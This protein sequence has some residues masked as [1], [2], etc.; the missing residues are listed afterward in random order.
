MSY[1]E[2]PPEEMQRRAVAFREDMQRRRSVREFSTRTV[3]RD[4]IEHCVLTAGS[5]PSGANQQPWHFVV[6][7]DAAVKHRIREAAEEREY[8]FYHELAGD[9]WLAALSPLGTDPHKPFLETAPWLI[10]VFAQKYGVSPDGGK[11]H[12]YFVRESVGIAIGMLIAAVHNAGLASLPY[13]PSQASFLNDLL[14]RPDHE[15]P[16]MILVVGYPARDA[17]VP[18]IT[19]K[20][21]SE[22]ATFL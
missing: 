14:G 17:V 5:A 21:L 18:N 12:H 8:A 20:G 6:V 11:T 3:P 22:I 15:R 16:I 9:E 13:T 7:G 10:A 2:Y 19:R 1:R 4:I